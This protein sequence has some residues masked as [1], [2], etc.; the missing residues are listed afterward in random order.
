MVQALSKYYVLPCFAISPFGT[1]GKQRA[2]CQ[3]GLEVAW[4][5]W[6]LLTN[7][8]VPHPLKKDVIVVFITARMVEHM[9][10]ITHAHVKSLISA[11]VT[12]YIYIYIYMYSVSMVELCRAFYCEL[13]AAIQRYQVT[14]SG[15]KTC[16]Y[17]CN[18]SCLVSLVV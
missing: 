13:L 11:Q 7:A 18:C 2:A 1:K 5:Q 9:T 10:Y 15:C 6:H 17:N 3:R 4:E 8:P 14:S 16:I 12:G